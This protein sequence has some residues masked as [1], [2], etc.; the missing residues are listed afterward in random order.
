MFD[1]H[2]CLKW[3][4]VSGILLAWLLL[5]VFWRA[6]RLSDQ[7]HLANPNSSGTP[8][9]QRSRDAPIRKRARRRKR[10]QKARHP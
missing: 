7:E 2:F 8:H 6:A 10:S 3:F 5:A 9:R 4:M 1:T